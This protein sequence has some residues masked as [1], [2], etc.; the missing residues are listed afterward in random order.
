MSDD[1]HLALPPHLSGVSQTILRLVHAHGEFQASVAVTQIF[2]ILLAN[3]TLLSGE[4]SS[5]P[6]SV[7]TKSDMHLIV[8]M[9]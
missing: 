7:I 9:I 2:V 6:S 5:Y 3:W 1:S 4:E 8:F